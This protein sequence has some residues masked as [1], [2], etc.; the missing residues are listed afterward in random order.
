[1]FNSF[2]KMYFVP[3]VGLCFPI[4]LCL[5]TS[6]GTTLGFFQS[7]LQ[8]SGMHSLQD[9]VFTDSPAGPHT[10]F[11]AAHFSS[12]V[13]SAPRE[14]F[15]NFSSDLDNSLL[16]L[17]CAV[18]NAGS[19]ALQQALSSGLLLRAPRP[20]ANQ[21]DQKLSPQQSPRSWKAMLISFALFMHLFPPGK[22]GLLAHRKVCQA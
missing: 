2:L 13:S 3:L 7:P 6:P 12:L 18:S 19:L 8:P 14:S 22:T 17:L 15:C 4:S 1:M 9:Q 11:P 21:E 20:S 10:S 5:A 16:P